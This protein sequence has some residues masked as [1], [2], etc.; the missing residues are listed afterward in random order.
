[1]RPFTGLAVPIGIVLAGIWPASAAEETKVPV[2][3]FA[4]LPFV[5]SVELSP[6]GDHVAY[7]ASVDGRVALATRTV[8]SDDFRVLVGTDNEHE[9]IRWFCWG[10]DDWLLVS[11]EYPGYRDGIPTSE[12]RLVRVRR[13]GSKPTLF[14]TPTYG[15]VHYSQLQDGIVGFLPRD[16]GHILVA[17]DDERA[18]LPS[19][20]EVGVATGARRLVQGFRAPI[21]DWMADQQGRVRIGLGYDDGV[22]TVIV[23]DTDSKE[24]RELWRYRAIQ[25]PAIEVLGFGADPNTLYV[26]ALHEGRNAVFSIDLRDRES[27]RTLKAHHPTLDIDGDLIYSPKTRDVVGVYDQGAD[28]SRI[29]WDEAYRALQRG[30]DAALPDTTNYLISFSRDERRYIVFAVSDVN[31]G[32]YYLGERD[33]GSLTPFAKTYP[34]LEGRPL[35]GKQ[36][37]T[38]AAR[39]GVIIEGYLTRPWYGRSPPWPTVVLPHGGPAARDTATFDFVTEFL[40]S[41]GYAVLQMNFRGSSGYGW[42]FMKSGFADLGGR[43]QDD[44]TDGARWLVG[45]GL[46]DPQ[47]LCIMGLSYGGYAALWG[48]VKTPDLY[49]CA[50]SVNGVSDW[51]MVLAESQFYVRGESA[52]EQLGERKDL[53]VVSPLRRVSEIGPPVL[54]A[55]GE[56]D[57]IVPVEHSRRMAKA[58]K[59]HGKEHLYIELKNGDHQLSNERNRAILLQAVESFLARYLGATAAGGATAEQGAK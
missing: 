9:R 6:S 45:Q 29:Y 44:V 56:A 20:Y 47:R 27:R 17:L 34:Q 58:L 21:R 25:Q 8:G 41:R 16:P 50:I 35:S 46:A 7:L 32:V 5:R 51:N 38:Y 48:A 12:T 1:M 4:R 11:A 13:D 15:T 30:V 57:R 19:V 10:N 40:A 37:L 3:D 43:M 23:R 31:P 54:L 33:T 42:D 36:P 59:K 53:A 22:E 2:Q 26:R 52:E 24:W 49:R 39:D 28:G 55:H 14:F 18:N